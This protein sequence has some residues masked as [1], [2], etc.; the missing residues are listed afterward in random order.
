MNFALVPIGI[1]DFEFRY[2]VYVQTIKPYIDD[3][4]PDWDDDQ[5]REMM[6]SNL[7]TGGNHFAIVID[8]VR[9]GIVQI[10]EY[11]H[12]LSIDQLEILPEHQGAGIGTAVM[13]SLM[14][15]AA[16]I[17]K[18]LELQVF[19]V[20]TGAREL[21][22]RLGFEVVKTTDLDLHMSYVPS[23]VGCRVAGMNLAP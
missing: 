6:R 3:R 20:N 21:Y 17:M 11:D 4:F 15:R 16:T 19:V 2:G 22:E 23:G 8:D 9:V 14:S 1:D 13:R 7:T 18:P 5:H 10:S 12:L